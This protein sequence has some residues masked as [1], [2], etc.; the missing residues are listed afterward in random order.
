MLQLAQYVWLFISD[1]QWTKAGRLNSI[2]HSLWN[3]MTEADSSILTSVS[4]AS[5]GMRRQKVGQKEARLYDLDPA[6]LWIPWSLV[7]LGALQRM[8]LSFIP[9]T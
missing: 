6:V 1:F 7:H 2:F 5:M 9:S 4:Q 3:C 8:T